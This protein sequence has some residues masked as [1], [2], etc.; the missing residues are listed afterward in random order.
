MSRR[1][2][3]VVVTTIAVMTQAGATQAAEIKVL[4]SNALNVNEAYVEFT[5][6]FERASGHR[7][8]TTFTAGWAGTPEITKRLQDGEVYDLVVGTRPLIDDMIKEGRLTAASRIDLAKSGVGV[9]VR[10]GAPKPD[11]A[12]TEAFKRALLAARS[13]GYS[14]GPSGVYLVGLIQRL[15]LADEITPKLRQT[16]GPRLLVGHLVARGETELGIQQV[17]ELLHFPGIQYVGPLPA[18]I[19]ETTVFSGALH[20]GATQAD[21]AKAFIRF[22]TSPDTTPVIRKSGMEPG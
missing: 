19:Q 13:I 20:P 11:I 8:T 4:S 1:S 5:S 3:A 15:G 21:A 10:E 2:I 17:S 6:M 9:A 18:D 14:Q 16:T 12:S 22:I 7:V